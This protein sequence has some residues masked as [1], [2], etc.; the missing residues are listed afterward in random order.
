MTV[1]K[2]KILEVISELPDK[3]DFEELLYRFY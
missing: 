2:E 1:A 3:V